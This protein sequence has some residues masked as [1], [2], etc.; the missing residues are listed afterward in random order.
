VPRSLLVA[1]LCSSALVIGCATTPHH[2]DQP[3]PRAGE[4]V[5]TG[6]VYADRN[7]NGVRDP[8]EPGV[9]QVRVS[10]GRAVVLTDRAG[11]YC[12]PRTDAPFV[13]VIKPRDWS[14]PLDAD[15]HPVFYAAVPAPGAAQGAV[16]LDFGLRHA[17]E[18]DAFD[19]LLLGDPQPRDQTE[20]RYVMRDIIEPLGGTPAA[21]AVV[22]GD[23]VFDNL[24]LHSAVKQAFGG[25]GIPVQFVM[26]NHDSDYQSP[27]DAGARGAF[28]RV[29]GPAYYAFDYGPVHFIVLEDIAW[30]GVVGNG[31]KYHSGLGA[32][33][34]EFVRNDLAHVPHNQLVV[35]AMHIPIH[36]IEEKAELY[37]VLAQHPN[38]VSFSGHDHAYEHWSLGAA[39]GWP[40]QTPHE[41]TSVGATCGGWW[42]G[43]PDELG[44]PHATVSDGTPN[45][46]AV[47]H[48][49]GAQYAV[50]FRAARRPPSYQMNI[51]AP[52]R[53]SGAASEPA[54]V[55][56]NVFAGSLRSQVELSVDGGAWA[57]LEHTQGVIDPYFAALKD[58]EKKEPPP[59]GRKLPGRHPSTHIWRGHVP[60]GL[61][62]GVHRLA[63]RTTD[64]YG[65]TYTAYRLVE[66]E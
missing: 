45:G 5:I 11:R 39:Q 51:F 7:G 32:P 14:P 20:V 2:G 10:D 8:G 61:T 1:G 23:L 55:L 13:F 34:L 15:R 38:V 22:L 36:E 9:A 28:E 54:E 30:E 46:W 65:Q 6:V 60:T 44:I 52:E 47:L 12:L 16:A 62:P 27:T 43:V 3:A 19:V 57:A 24:G 41:H 31:D 48:C 66:V 21:F 63:V 40:G 56:V 29:F 59:P 58:L 42:S 4:P 25:L 50:A 49:R 64:M 18:P 17:P 33:Q 35:L 53:I 37:S 26:G